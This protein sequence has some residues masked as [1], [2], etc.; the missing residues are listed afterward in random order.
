MADVQILTGSTKAQLLFPAGNV[1]TASFTNPVPLGSNPAFINGS[2]QAGY[3]PLGQDGSVT[4]NSFGMVF[5]GQGSDTN[6][7]AAQIFGWRETS[8][9]VTA[10]NI[11][12]LWFP[13][14]LCTLTPIE[15]NSGMPGVA[16]TDVGSSNYFAS[17]ITLSVGNANVSVEVVSPTHANNMIAHVIVTTKGFRYAQVQLSINSSAT[18][19][20]ALWWKI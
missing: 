4:A 17:D 14:C 13:V 5:F 18:N 1:T 15:L 9:Y 10:G 16:G 12:P 19:V 2:L 11:N 7:M 8:A 3:I 20:N 6:T